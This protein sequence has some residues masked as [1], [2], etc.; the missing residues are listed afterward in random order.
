M[1]CDSAGNATSIRPGHIAL[2]TR[3]VTLARVRLN[4]VARSPGV[5]LAATIAMACAEQPD[6]QRR[7]TWVVSR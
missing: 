6:T 5:V 4:L 1:C 7:V 2:V 3:Y